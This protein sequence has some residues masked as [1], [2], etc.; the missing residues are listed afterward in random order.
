MNLLDQTVTVR[1]SKTEAGERVIPLNADAMGAIH[2]LFKRS[3]TFNGSELNHYVFSACATRANVPIRS[4]VMLTTSTGNEWTVPPSSVH[5]P[6][7]KTFG[8]FSLVLSN[9]QQRAVV[10]PV[11]CSSFGNSE[12]ID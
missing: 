1:H 10:L 6:L 7:F 3:E 11:L 5:F 2:E 12:G 8:F 9:H 4:V